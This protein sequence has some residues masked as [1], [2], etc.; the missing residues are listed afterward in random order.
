MWGGEPA[1]DSPTKQPHVISCRSQNKFTAITCVG[2]C[3]NFPKTALGCHAD[4]AK[5]Q[6]LYDPQHCSFSPQHTLQL[7]AEK[8]WNYINILGAPA[9]HRT[10]AL[11]VSGIS[12]RTNCMSGTVAGLWLFI[13][14]FPERN[15]RSHNHT[16]KQLKT[17]HR[18]QF[19]ACK[20]CFLELRKHR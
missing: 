10:T 16:M 7:K 20:G 13:P 8:P 12:A 19:L 4:T 9:E 18:A 6:H 17:V 3:Q 1:S 2:S 5:A 15:A 14:K 11:S